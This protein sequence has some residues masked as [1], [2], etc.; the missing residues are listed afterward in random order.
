MHH[1]VDVLVRRRRLVDHVL[2]LAALHTLRGGHMIR[3][4]ELLPRRRARHRTSSAM[5]AAIE[6]LSIPQ[7]AHDERT[8]AHAARNDAHLALASTYR[9]LTGHQHV[10]AEMVL[11]RDVVVMA[12]DCLDLRFE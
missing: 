5:A 4:G 2:I 1:R 11:A 3:Q 7:A 12:V 9:A 8:R 6:T 10:L